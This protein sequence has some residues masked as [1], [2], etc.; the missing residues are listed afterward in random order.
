M[1]L[2][3]FK[4][5]RP[6]FEVPSG[7]NLMKSLLEAGL[8][9]ASSCDGDGVCAKCK[10]TIVEGKENLTPEN[11]TEAFLRE[12]KDLPKDVRIS[13]QTQVIGDVT[14]DATYW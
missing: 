5:N 11:E 7:A 6:A 1:P 13:C 4:K 3:S 9:V 10:I 2:I 12:S 8:P 14:V